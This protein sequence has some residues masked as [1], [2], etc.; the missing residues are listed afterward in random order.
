MICIVRVISNVAV[1]G[2]A[3]KTDA[4]ITNT[5]SV[6]LGEVDDKV[7]TIPPSSARVKPAYSPPKPTP[8][9]FKP[10]D[11]SN[12]ARVAVPAMCAVIVACAALSN[13]TSNLSTA[14]RVTSAV[15]C[16]VLGWSSSAVIVAVS[17]PVTNADNVTT[18][19]PEIPTLARALSAATPNSYSP[20]PPGRAGV[21]NR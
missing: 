14:L 4:V 1:A 2:L 12:V 8:P 3:S 6:A 15:A 7:I 17:E 13:N 18:L 5:L 10:P 11:A 16:S 21:G 20:F 19:T 9:R